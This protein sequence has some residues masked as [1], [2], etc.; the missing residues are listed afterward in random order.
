M[1]DP[2]NIAHDKK[3][4]Q[5]KKHHGIA[6]AHEHSPLG[7]KQHQE[8]HPPP[9]QEPATGNHGPDAD[10]AIDKTEYGQ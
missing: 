1:T 7:K 6:S 2:R 10:E 8:P 3:V 5:E 4:E 9:L